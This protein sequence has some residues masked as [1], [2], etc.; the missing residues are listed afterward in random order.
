MIKVA[1]LTNSEYMINTI[2]KLNSIYKLLV[3]THRK[4]PQ[5]RGRKILP[6]TI[7]DFCRK[8]NIEYCE[9]D[10]INKDFSGLKAFTPDA[11]VICDFKDIL[12]EEVISM[13]KIASV[14][15]H[16]SLLPLY[17]GASPIQ[18]TLLNGD[19]FTGFSI[20]EI[21]P[22]VDS[23]RIYYQKAVPVYEWDNYLTLK[24]R[25]F[26]EVEHC[27]IDISRR[28]ISKSID[29]VVQNERE[30]TYCK[31]FT[32]E[33]GKITWLETAHTICNKI[34]AFYKWPC[35]HFYNRKNERINIIVANVIDYNSSC[36]P[37]TIVNIN[38]FGIA[39]QTKDKIL[40]I[41]KLKPENRKIMSG[42]DYVNGYKLK[43]GEI[44]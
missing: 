27:I 35:V 4:K 40:N 26:D 43:K 2:T 30:V 33:D 17:R 9:V 18:S 14:N 20:I 39:V 15:I 28:I 7:A 22:K 19:S 37:G 42:L 6:S 16:P 3:I 29:G 11:L 10:N 25:I 13:G 36:L 34:R 38:S 12:K 44:L 31:K 8:N 23:G 1:I 24:K 5:G 32:K 21:A 41:I